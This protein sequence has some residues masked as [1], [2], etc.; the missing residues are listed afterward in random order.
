MV[1][2]DDLLWL[3]KF[4][5][6]DLVLLGVEKLL[7]LV[8]EM[9]CTFWT[10]LILLVHLWLLIHHMLINFLDVW[11]FWC[12]NKVSV[13]LLSKEDFINFLILLLLLLDF[14]KNLSEYG[15]VVSF[16]AF[17]RSLGSDRDSAAA[18]R[19]FV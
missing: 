19:R 18:F 8:I 4:I 12:L 16:G 10:L 14:L 7:D 11:V 15:I 1:L 9:E 3:E 17:S 6:S 5:L 2:S 13:L